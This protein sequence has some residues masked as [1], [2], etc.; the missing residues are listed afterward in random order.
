[1]GTAL[2]FGGTRFFGKQLVNV[3][4]ENSYEVTIATRGLT[5]DTYK[6]SVKRI[7]VDR[8]DRSS[9]EK[10]FCKQYYD[11]IFDNICYSPNEA[12]STSEVFKG[13]VGRY[14]FTSTLS[15]YEEGMG[16]KEEDYDPYGYSIRFG[17][18]EAFD[19][20]EG[21]R[22][23][24][25][26]FFQKAEF[27]VIAVR[28]PV[29]I[30][31]EDYTNRLLSYYEAI[32]QDTPLYIDNLENKMVFI[33]AQEAGRFLHWI[34]TTEFK[35]PINACTNG[36]IKINEIIGLCE[37]KAKKKWLVGSQDSDVV[38]AF[39]GFYEYT[40]DNGK[41]K[42]MGFRFNEIKTEV[43]ALLGKEDL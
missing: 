14:I 13:K 26:V 22:L 33:T 21:K 40:L 17:E 42:Q 7:T 12:I 43:E 27:P 5:K 34:S 10:V 23:A 4:L 37:E 32:V 1:M 11:L 6:N 19:Y 9:L 2:V 16:H 25:A 28:F 18:R 29:V 31:K 30:G 3:L 15:V 8:N 24:E 20:G 41:A 36:T 35:G 39:N 38:G